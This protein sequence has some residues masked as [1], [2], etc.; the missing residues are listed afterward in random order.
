MDREEAAGALRDVDLGRRRSTALRGY[1]DAGSTIIVWGLVWLICNLATYFV[2]GGYRSWM[3][4]IPLG[5]I[6]SIA[7]PYLGKRVRGNDADWRIPLSVLAAFVF[8]VLVMRVTG[9]DGSHAQQNVLISL[10]VA[11]AYVIGGIW[12]GLRFAL[13]GI[14]L[15]LVICVGWFAYPETLLL[16]LGIGGGGALILGGIWLRQA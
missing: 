11:V 4:G 12:A 9:A 10:L 15:T 3:I 13:L 1:T 8:L 2:A 5:I 14:A 16:W 7:H 6:W